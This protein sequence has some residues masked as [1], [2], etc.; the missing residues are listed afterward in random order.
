MISSPKLNT[1][2][3][4]IKTGDVLAFRSCTLWSRLIRL[5]TFSRVSHVGFAIWIRGKLCVIEAVEWYAIRV[6]P[7][8]H[9]LED[10]RYQVDHYELLDERYGIDRQLVIDTAW[11]LLGKRYASHW[12]FVRSWGLLTRRIANRLGWEIDTDPGRYHCSETVLHCLRAGGYR[13]DGISGE[14]DPSE[15]SPGDIVELPC[16][17]HAGAIRC[18]V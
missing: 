4:H 16:L 10:Q 18:S 17:H 13:G 5:R 14:K 15:T 2:F 6:W 11:D 7:L 12:Q 1:A 8:E 3:D 9:Y